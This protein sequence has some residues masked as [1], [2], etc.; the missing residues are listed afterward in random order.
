MSKTNLLRALFCA[1]LLL[2]SSA[3]A[4]PDDKNQPIRVSADK[5]SMNETTGISVYT[6]NVEIRQGSMLLTGARVE[7]H[8][9]KEGNISRIISTGSP[10]HF[11][12]QATQNQP[13]TKAYGLQMD[14]RVN[15]QLITITEQARVEQ[16]GDNFTGERIVYNME[17]SI[18]DAF[19]SER[20]GGQRV[21]MI[22]Q[23]K[24]SN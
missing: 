22:I 12:Q 13:V 23:P 7:M 21:E 10:A 1:G 18:V 8:R 2:A 20:S 19:G 6:G 3:Q 14:Y 9:D 24:A 11:Q 5:A 4:L 17:K 16:A 15:A